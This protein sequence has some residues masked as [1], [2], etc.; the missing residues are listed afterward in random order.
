MVNS[1][2]Q[3]VTSTSKSDF[4]FKTAL[5]GGRGGSY[6]L[7]VVP[8]LAS[9]ALFFVSPA[10]AAALQLL[11]VCALVGKLPFF[12]LAIFAAMPFQQ[13]L[14]GEGAVNVSLVDILAALLFIVLL[15]SLPGRN[16]LRM[17]PIAA[18]LLLYLGISCAS[19][20]ANWEGFTTAVSLARMVMA[21][22]VAILIFANFSTALRLAHRGFL[23]FLMALNVLALF[24]MA[25]F[26]QGGIEAS[27]YTLGINKN[28]LGPTFGCGIITCLGYLLTERAQGRRKTF[29]FLSLGLSTIGIFLSLSRGAWVATAVAFLLLLVMVKNKRA[30]WGSLLVMVPLVAILW[31]MLPQE[32]AEYA[33]D[34]SSS[35]YT[36][37]TRLQTI[38]EVLEAFRSSPLMGVG[39]GIRKEADPH[40]VL[41]L[42]LGES[43]LVGL[44]GFI[45]MFAG[46][47]YTL[48]L[49]AKKTKNDLPNK[50]IVFIGASVLL[51]SLVHGCMD[52]Y[53]RRGVGFL[54]WACVGLAVQ[55]LL[56][57]RAPAAASPMA[58]PVENMRSRKRQPL[59]KRQ[60]V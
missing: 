39:I 19:S 47:F 30:F 16:S 15:S 27:M 42:T 29:L 7:A 33:T 46:G 17:G 1:F 60:R 37:K 22:L 43:G 55:I 3:A 20:L 14:G 36:I 32:T 4:N 25:A 38:N 35:S 50:Q 34:V 58:V 57:A 56:S 13:S 44:A 45:G 23:V 31:Q 12:L 54:G 41:I 2:V 9:F 51:L 11:T 52:V 24:T 6:V 5:H 10:L 8:L 28:A 48:F 49:A 21:T 59:R 40:N 53:W 18:P 26:A